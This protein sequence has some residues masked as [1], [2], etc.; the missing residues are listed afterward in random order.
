MMS[1]V[2]FEPKC[3]APTSL[4]RR[5]IAMVPEAVNVLLLPDVVA[6]VAAAETL[7]VGMLLPVSVDN[8]RTLVPDDIAAAAVVV[9]IGKSLYCCCCCCCCLCNN[10]SCRQDV[11][12]EF[13]DD[14]KSF[15]EDS[16]NKALISAG[17][18][19]VKN[20][21]RRTPGNWTKKIVYEKFREN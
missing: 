19:F 3:A 18:G 16:D 17:M 4:K 5:P 15:S 6:A 7:V 12:V 13:K 20:L 10:K 9:V 8:R 21:A 11:A 1:T 14:D 2:A